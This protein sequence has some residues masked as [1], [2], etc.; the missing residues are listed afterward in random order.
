MTGW[1]QP[2]PAG[3]SWDH[4]ASLDKTANISESLNKSMYYSYKDM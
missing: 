3:H 1:S 4:K 2:E